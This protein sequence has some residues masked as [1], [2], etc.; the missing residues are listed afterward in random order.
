M[1]CHC[2]IPEYPIGEPLGDIE[3]EAMPKREKN[4][5]ERFLVEMQE[6]T[7]KIPLLSNRGPN[8]NLS[9]KDCLEIW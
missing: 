2:V 6:H 7:D 4:F 9:Y 3:L 8:I 1:S 5:W